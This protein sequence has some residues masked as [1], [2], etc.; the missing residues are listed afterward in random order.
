MPDVH[1]RRRIAAGAG[2]REVVPGRRPRR[3]TLR[4]D[5]NRRSAGGRPGPRRVRG[6]RVVRHRPVRRGGRPGGLRPAARGGIARRRPAR[7]PAEVRR[8]RGLGPRRGPARAE[9]QDRDRAEDSRDVHGDHSDP[10]ETPATGAGP[11]LT[12]PREPVPRQGG[13]AD[14]LS[15]RLGATP[16]SRRRAASRSARACSAQSCVPEDVAGGQDVGAVVDRPD[17]DPLRAPPGR[18]LARPPGRRERRSGPAPFGQ[19]A[20][21]RDPATTPT[22]TPAI[23]A[24]MIDEGSGTTAAKAVRAINLW[25]AVVGWTVSQNR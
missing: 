19:A 5:C 8:G 17:V 21:R 7:R 18:S 11:S 13:R 23:A 2:G 22:P 4:S 9:D 14:A 1:R 15:P 12:L 25:T 24:R 10:K 6:Q 20:R 3:C 16:I